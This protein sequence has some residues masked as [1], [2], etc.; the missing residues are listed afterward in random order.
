MSLEI[1]SLGLDEQRRRRVESS[2][3]NALSICT[4]GE[5]AGLKYVLIRDSSSLSSM[6]RKERVRSRG[7]LVNK[8]RIVGLYRHATRREPAGLELFI[9][10][11]FSSYPGWFFS[12]EA[13]RTLFLAK[14]L[15]HEV[16]HHL[17]ATRRVK[18]NPEKVADSFRDDLMKRLGRSRYRW[19]IWIRWPLRWIAR[20]LRALFLSERGVEG[21]KSKS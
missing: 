8:K 14:V 5:L 19:L 18:G 3:V 1:R 7:G 11:I 15:F 20:L 12:L 10:K 6:E 21:E 2:V 16:G 4:A 13:L 9:D 17:Q